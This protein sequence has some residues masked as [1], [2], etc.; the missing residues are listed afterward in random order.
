MINCHNTVCEMKTL[1]TSGFQNDLKHA[2][3]SH[4]QYHGMDIYV[5]KMIMNIKNPIIGNN[6]DY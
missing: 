6:Q 1:E 5:E 4:S 3:E 2:M